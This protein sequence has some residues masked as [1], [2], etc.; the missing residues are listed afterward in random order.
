MPLLPV[1]KSAEG[2]P[3]SRPHG[4][5]QSS[6]SVPIPLPCIPTGLGDEAEVIWGKISTCYLV[7]IT[8][9]LKPGQEQSARGHWQGLEQ[10][11]LPSAK[12]TSLPAQPS[13]E[14]RHPSSPCNLL[15]TSPQVWMQKRSAQRDA[16]SLQAPGASRGEPSTS[17]KLAGVGR[18]L[19]RASDPTPSSSSNTKA[20]FPVPS[21]SSQC[22]FHLY[23]L[24]S[25]SPE[26]LACSDL[27]LCPP[28]PANLGGTQPTAGGDAGWKSP[29]QPFF[30]HVEIIWRNY[31]R[32]PQHGGAW[33]WQNLPLLLPL[34]EPWHWL[35]EALAPRWGSQAERRGALTV[36][37]CLL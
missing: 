35:Q 30:F 1:P 34:Q 22:F 20:A 36:G 5:G 15:Y 19:L 24:S 11:M 26:L 23:T 28:C 13:P 12:T 27:S 7:L 2:L 33:G 17:H 10:E 14:Q 18:D 29:A 6:T 8:L 3:A 25:F 16:M 9:L 37:I 31:Y 21:V 32:G 4:G